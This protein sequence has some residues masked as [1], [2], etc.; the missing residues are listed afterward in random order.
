[1]LDVLRL[2]AV[3]W[4]TTFSRQNRPQ[5]IPLLTSMQGHQVQEK[6]PNHT[7]LDLSIEG[8]KLLASHSDE[9]DSSWLSG[10]SR[11]RTS[12]RAQLEEFGRFIHS[13]ILNFCFKLANFCICGSIFNIFR[14][15]KSSLHAWPAYIGVEIVKWIF[16]FVMDAT[17]SPNFANSRA[18]LL[19]FAAAGRPRLTRHSTRNFEPSRIV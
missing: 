3:L 2:V 8:S 11:E 12:A 14:F 1:M 17:D 19:P 6:L 13:K 18:H 5:L 16:E 7:M 9:S 15:L 10:E 4:P